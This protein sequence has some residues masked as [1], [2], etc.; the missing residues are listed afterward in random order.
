MASLVQA[1]VVSKC[2]LLALYSDAREPA[3][4]SAVASGHASSGRAARLPASSS[5]FA[6]S[7]LSTPS[8]R[9]SSRQQS[10][11][12]VLSVSAVAQAPRRSQPN[13]DEPEYAVTP[14]LQIT[15]SSGP[16]GRVLLD[17]EVP[18]DACLRAYELVLS[19]MAKSVRVPGYRPGKPVPRSLLIQH[20]GRYRT[21]A[22]AVEYL[23]KE[24][25][26]QALQRT[27]KRAVDGSERIETDFETMIDRFSEKT[28]LKFVI[29]VDV[30]PEISW[31]APEGYK[32]LSVEIQ[33]PSA[34]EEQKAADDAFLRRHKDLGRLGVATG[35]G[36]QKG[37]VAVINFSSTRVN[38]DGTPGDRILGAEGQ[39][40]QL[41]TDEESRLLPGFVSSLLGAT[42]GDERVFDLT[43]P[44]I[45]EPAALRGQVGRFTAT[46]TEIF[47]RDLPELTDDL[48]QKFAA[49][50]N[51]IAEAKTVL[52]EEIKRENKERAEQAIQS[53]LMDALAEI[54]VVQL[55]EGLI[56]EQGRQLYAAKLLELQ[57]SWV[58]IKW[59]W[60]LSQARGQIQK[61]QID[62]LSTPTLVKA[63]IEKERADIERI[64]RGT[65]A[66]SEVFKLENL[67]IPEEDFNHELERAR[68][69]FNRVQQEFDDERLK[70][71]V[72]EFLEGAVVL[73]FLKKTATFKYTAPS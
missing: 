5:S 73:E 70:E 64:V 17:V 1:V 9:R 48:A 14:G 47:E 52:L 23:L 71:Q 46:V 62:S 50:A 58:F 53:A 25:L 44:D 42:V 39:G 22:A 13:E 2:G 30:M 67:S 15:E 54:C 10:S 55:P 61:N 45:W 29:G 65:V 11:R 38:A 63:Y 27:A 20:I 66:A 3:Q 56:E 36:I 34:E 31:T 43:F 16:T 7:S 19:K 28:P 57:A 41:D 32:R 60:L 18:A 33:V 21:Q 69:E 4:C 35:R 68:S 40:F 49:G 6:S 37:D 26:P 24:T 8:R 59:I 12:R 51:T 72:Q